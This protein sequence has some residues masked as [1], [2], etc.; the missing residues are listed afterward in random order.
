MN[1]GT[2]CPICEETVKNCTCKS[3][4]KAFKDR[5]EWV[6]KRIVVRDHLYLFSDDQIRH[7]AKLQKYWNSKYGDPMKAKILKNMEEKYSL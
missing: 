1:E 6:N 7:L 3:L 2:V 5:D 4:G